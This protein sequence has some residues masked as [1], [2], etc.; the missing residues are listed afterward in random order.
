MKLK[1]CLCFFIASFLIIGNSGLTTFAKSK[2][3]KLS[4][5]KMIVEIEQSSILELKNAN[6]KVKWSISGKKIVGL[7]RAKNTPKCK[8]TAKKA[9][10]T[11]VK[12]K[13]KKKTYKC[14]VIVKKRT[15]ATTSD[16][17]SQEKYSKIQQQN[18]TVEPDMII[19]HPVTS[20]QNALTTTS[21]GTNEIP[22]I[23][24]EAPIQSTE[25]FNTTTEAPPVTTEEPIGHIHVWTEW[26][27][28]EAATC[29]TDGIKAR[30]CPCGELETDTISAI[31]HRNTEIR[32][33]K[34]ASCITT[35]YTGDIYCTDCGSL[36]QQGTEIEEMEH[37]FNE[38]HQ[39]TL[40]G[41]FDETTAVS[42]TDVSE[43]KNGGILCYKYK[44]ADYTVDAPYY[45]IYIKTIKTGTVLKHERFENVQYENITFVNDV[46]LG[47]DASYMFFGCE[48]LKF[49]NV[50]NLDTSHVENMEY[51]FGNCTS[52]TNLDVSNFDTSKVTN[53]FSMFCGCESLIALD[54][55]NFNTENV[56][57]TSCMFMLCKKLTSLNL[58]SF[59]TSM[60][61]DMNS[62]FMNCTGLQKLELGDFDTK[63]VKNMSYMFAF[64]FALTS[65][66]VSS[67][68][69]S[70]VENMKYM[71]GYCQ[72]LQTLDLNH[73]NTKNVKDMSYMFAF[74]YK[75]QNLGIYSF[76]TSNVTNMDSIFSNCKVLKTLDLTRFNTSKVTNMHHAFDYCCALETLDLTSFNTTNVTN[77]GEMFYGSDN[78]TAIYVGNNWSIK[79][80]CITSNMFTNCGCS[81]VTFK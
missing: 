7:K 10:K 2:K 71:F 29:T 9:G 40:C 49:L 17:V 46:M 16:N 61:E 5:A 69:T 31:G 68:D 4:K 30:S 23:T 58:N 48:N 75:L 43:E 37:D 8:I 25:E 81:S 41:T 22:I 27:T 21:S 12:A 28:I 72:Q 76:N 63:N 39:C 65:L 45:D 80:D 78:L 53:M 57:A 13:Y 15:A 35:G 33:Q 54:V 77:M 44:S 66:D 11:V 20:T 70:N 56:K 51:M 42:V 62:M 32:N 36:V 1:R 52:L 47:K 64:C 50:Q 19:Q 14:V 3:T 67:F 18:T 73:F 59:D 38:E 24:T 79:G 74:C 55:S 34:D 60:V 26:K 6:G